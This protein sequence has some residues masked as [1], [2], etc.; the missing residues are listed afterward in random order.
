MQ[1]IKNEVCSPKLEFGIGKGADHNHLY[2]RVNGQIMG[3]CHLYA[4]GGIMFHPAYN[5]DEEIPKKFMD[6][7][8]ELTFNTRNFKLF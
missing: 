6:G 8:R 5:R 4:S 3:Y 1:A 7:E 2:I